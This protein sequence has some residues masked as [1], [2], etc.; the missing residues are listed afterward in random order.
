[1]IPASPGTKTISIGGSIC[2]A[3]RDGPWDR[4]TQSPR[5]RDRGARHCGSHLL[6]PRVVA[7]GALY[8][9]LMAQCLGAAI[10]NVHIAA[11]RKQASAAPSSDLLYDVKL[12]QICECLHHC[13]V[14]HFQRATR[15]YDTDDGLTLKQIVDVQGGGH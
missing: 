1:M 3:P 6:R 8:I 13:R 9:P 7:L 14:G 4:S 11:I 2:G 10:K 15:R 12:L 5:R